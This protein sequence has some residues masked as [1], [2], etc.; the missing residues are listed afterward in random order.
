MCFS[1]VFSSWRKAVKQGY[2]AT[3]PGLSEHLIQKHLDKSVAT[4]KGNLTQQQQN[5]RST[6]TTR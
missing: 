2:I 3:W 1:P 5:L 4:S 6:R